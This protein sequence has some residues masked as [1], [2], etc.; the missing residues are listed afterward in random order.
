M[1]LTC[2]LGKSGC[3]KTHLI[4][5][6]IGALLLGGASVILLCPEQEAVIA[7][8]RTTERFSDKIPTVGLEILN[9]GRLPER[10]F[11]EYGGLTDQLLSEGGRR[12]LMH[13]TL[14]ETAPFLREYSRC[15]E[16]DLP[17]RW[18]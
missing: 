18:Q 14:A 12:L 9:F 7:E 13:R 3:G 11:R 6:E 17:H 15:C 1:M 8:R 5:E 10:V 16:D 2:V 4:T